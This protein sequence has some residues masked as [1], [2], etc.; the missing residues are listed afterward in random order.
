MGGASRPAFELVLSPDHAPGGALAAR[1]FVGQG[2]KLGPYKGALEVS[3]EGAVRL[4]GDTREIFGPAP[5]DFDVAVAVG[6]PGSI[7]EEAS[8][9]SRVLESP[10]AP[11]RFRVVVSPVHVEPTR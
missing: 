6:E 1:A 9:L 11:S 7:P 4:T 3:R 8:A 5:G 2:A 10:K